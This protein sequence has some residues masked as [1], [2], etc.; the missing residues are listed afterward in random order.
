MP[1]L[2]GLDADV[3]YGDPEKKLPNWREHDD[4]DDDGEEPT[5]EERAAVEG[6]LGVKLASLWGSE[7]E[8]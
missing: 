6:V 5:P 8:V 7:K 4:K 2:P 1:Q 3:Y